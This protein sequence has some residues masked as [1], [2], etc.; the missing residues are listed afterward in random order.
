MDTHTHHQPP[1]AIGPTLGLTQ[2]EVERASL[3]GYIRA[4]ALDDRNELA[5][6]N[7]LSEQVARET[8]RAATQFGAYLVP[9]DVT[10]R[11]MTKGTSSAGGYLVGTELAGFAS[12]LDAASLIGRLPMTRMSNLVGDVTIARETVKGTAGWITAEGTTAP[13]AQSTFGQIGLQPKVC[14]AVVTITRQLLKQTGPAAQAFVDRALAVTLGEAIDRSLIAGAGSDGSPLGI[15][16]T[17]GVDVRA[18]TSFAWSDALAM[19]KVAAGWD[20]S[21]SRGWVLGVDAAEDLAQRERAAGSGFILD[22][23]A[24]DGSPAV[25]SRSVGAATAVV[26]PWSQVWMAS[27]GALQVAADP[28]AY[29]RDGRLQVRVLWSVDFAIENPSAVA[30]ASAV[31]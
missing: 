31:T 22:G 25:V 13:A 28:S 17:P 7:E 16:A 4:M 10:R 19:G 30:V 1:R 14:A 29:F 15:A 27:W 6:F 26:A 21:P 18:G 24:I 11:D 8:G 2:K 5:Y 23:G 20:S 3:F 12:A 9:G